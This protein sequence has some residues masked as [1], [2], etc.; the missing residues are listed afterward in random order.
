MAKKIDHTMKSLN[1]PDTLV[2]VIQAIADQ[3]KRSFTAQAIIFL[4]K[5]VARHV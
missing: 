3:E 5:S 2:E 1:L 4:E